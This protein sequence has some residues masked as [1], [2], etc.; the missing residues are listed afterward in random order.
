MPKLTIEI[1]EHEWELLILTAQHQ[2]MTPEQVAEQLLRTH[3]RHKVSR[4]NIPP[5]GSLRRVISTL[6]FIQKA[7]PLD[8]PPS[9]KEEIDAYLQAERDAWDKEA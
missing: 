3:L 4:R 7:F 6:D 5:R 1:D 2:H 8:T 9:S